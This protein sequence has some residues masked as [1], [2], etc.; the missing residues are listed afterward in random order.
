VLT[1]ASRQEYESALQ[2]MLAQAKTVSPLIET[3]AWDS[4]VAT[5]KAYPLVLLRSSNFGAGSP[6]ARLHSL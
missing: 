2:D 1:P 4:I 3:E 6:K 5:A